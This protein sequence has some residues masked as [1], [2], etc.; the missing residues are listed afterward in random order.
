M[1][2]SIK[3]AETVVVLTARGVRVLGK[4]R[5]KFPREK[6]FDKHMYFEL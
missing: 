6:P 2:S 4:V 3:V 5:G 1:D